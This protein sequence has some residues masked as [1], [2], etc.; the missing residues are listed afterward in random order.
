MK[1]ENCELGMVGLGVMGCNLLLNMADHGHAVA[2]YDKDQDKVEALRNRSKGM[3]VSAAADLES[4]IAALKKPRTVMLLVPAGQIV[5]KV[6]E[7]LRPALAE[8]DLIIDGGNSHFLDTDRRTDTLKGSGIH[9]IGMGVSGGSHGAR[10]GPSMMPGGSKEAYG[11]VQSLFEDVAAHVDGDPC[12]TYLGPRSAGHFVKMVHNGIEYGIMQ[13]IA[14]TY[15]MMKRGLGLS[16]DQ[17][18]DVYRKWNETEVRGFLVEITGDIFAKT[19]P[20]TGRM[21]VDVIRDQAKQK[22]T[23][24]WTSE[25]A[26]ELQCPTPVIDAAVSARDLSGLARQRR[27]VSKRYSVSIASFPGDPTEWVARLQRALYAGMIVTYAQG[28]SLLRS[29]SEKYNYGVKLEDVARIWRGG[30]IIRAALLED[31]RS[32]FHARPDLPT[33][34][35]DEHLKGQLAKRE[36]ALRQVVSQAAHAGIPAPA[37][38]AALA[39]FDGLR[40]EKLPANLIQA[41]RDFFGAHTYERVDRD[42]TFHTDWRPD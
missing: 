12:V 30:C 23:G 4:M 39:Y 40:S 41:Q 14:E 8:D 18:H 25:D 7:E 42:G 17:L 29:A 3:S 21:L 11:R 22:G 1:N 6:I 38:M 27:E 24:M 36:D 9:Y 13:L 31:I 26:M 33:L 32:A 34:L 15:D 16:N 10:R 5:D 37:T 28:L 35:L 20:D 2:G 19:D